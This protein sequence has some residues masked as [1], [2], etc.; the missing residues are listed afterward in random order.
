M[1][2]TQAHR[3]T[4]ILR[5]LLRWLDY[6]S[7]SYDGKR[8]KNPTCTRCSLLLTSFKLYQHKQF[9]HMLEYYVFCP[10]DTFSDWIFCPTIQCSF[11]PN[12]W[13]FGQP[14]RFDN[15]IW[16]TEYHTCSNT[17]SILSELDM[18]IISPGPPMYILSLPTL[19]NTK[20]Y[21]QCGM[22]SWPTKVPE[23]WYLIKREHSLLDL[24]L[25]NV[26]HSLW[27]YVMSWHSFIYE[28][29]YRFNTSQY[30]MYS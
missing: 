5:L 11:R 17:E 25:S 7:W 8:L 22:F 2:I 27:H 13:L 29:H 10:F 15:S 18:V 23:Q 28:L 16:S 19:P 24:R 6:D 26:A 14:S 30:T 20:T 21:L 3:Q 12:T 4:H 1:K 9:T